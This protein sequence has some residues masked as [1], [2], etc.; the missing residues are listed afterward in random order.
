MYRITLAC[1]CVKAAHA[2]EA[3]RDI[4][5][6]FTHRPW[7]QNV[8][9]EWD[10]SRLLLRAENDYDLD[11]LALMDEFSD[12][13]TAYVPEPLDGDIEVLSVADV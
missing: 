4:T 13:I 9:C 5:E 8:R 6:E 12:A 3:A 11:G 1:R 10:G 2:E 7:H